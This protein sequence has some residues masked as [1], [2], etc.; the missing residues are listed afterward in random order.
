MTDGVYLD[1][2]SRPNQYEPKINATNA[3]AVAREVADEL[4]SFSQNRESTE[5]PQDTIQEIHSLDPSRVQDLL[6]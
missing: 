2:A 3:K 1:R 5:N 4:K 6:A